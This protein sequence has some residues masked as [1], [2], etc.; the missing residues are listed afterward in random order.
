MARVMGM[1]MGIITIIEG[2]GGWSKIRHFRRCLGG[3]RLQIAD[4]APFWNQGR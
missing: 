4:I 3:R 1:T 2:G